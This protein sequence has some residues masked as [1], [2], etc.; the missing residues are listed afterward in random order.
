MAR[1]RTVKP[2][3]WSSEQV[4][5]CRPLAR[6]LFIG[7]WNFCDDGGNHPLSARTIKAL[8]FP[9]DDITVEEVSGLLGELEGANL[10]MSYWA[11]GKNYLHVRGWK[12]QKI[13]KKNFKYPSPPSEFDDQS[14]SGRRQFAEESSTSRQPFDPGRE[15]KGIGEDQH[16]TLGAEQENSVDPKLPTEMC[17]EWVPDQKLLKA[18]ALRMAIPVER[19]TPEATAAFVCHYSASGRCE[20]QAAWVSLLVKWVK[21]DE[22]SASNIRQF[23]ARRPSTEPDFDSNAW[24]EGLVVSP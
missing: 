8:V 15:G 3:F 2:E 21:R 23:P 6:L 20:T 1:I 4:M 7:I 11:G 14:A 19:F 5:S 9:G 22:A 18:Y 24:A 10:T 17:L 16:N 12:H 13:E